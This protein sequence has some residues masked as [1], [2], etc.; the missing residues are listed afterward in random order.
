MGLAASKQDYPSYLRALV[1]REIAPDDDQFWDAF[2]SMP[3]S[4]EDIFN[5]VKPD[6]VRHMKQQH[7]RNLAILL[8]KVKWN[9]A[10]SFMD[11]NCCI[12]CHPSV[13]RA[14]VL[15]SFPHKVS[16]Y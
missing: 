10:S 2:W 11:G 5:S 3:G 9:P 4:V 7:P 6:D 1:E 12:T 14:P 8:N 13:T 16:L 15:A